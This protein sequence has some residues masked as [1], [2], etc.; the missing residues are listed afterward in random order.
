MPR[1]SL[2]TLPHGQR[3][4]LIGEFYDAIASLKTRDEV[5]S[6]LRDLLSPSEIA[7]LMRRI[8]TAMLLA[9]GC[10]YNAI[11]ALTGIGKSTITGIHKKMARPNRGN[12]YHR[13]MSKVLE[14]R[15]KRIQQTRRKELRVVNAWEKSKKRY[16]LY[17]LL[18]VIADELADSRERKDRQFTL[19]ALRYTPSRT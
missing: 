10:S 2:T 15:K 19:R 3:M 4:Q 14:K 16:P 1:F 11:R 5:R 17:F 9:S 7:M 12:G 8:E 13:V 18:N 6:F